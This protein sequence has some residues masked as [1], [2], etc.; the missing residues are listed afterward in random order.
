MWEK[1]GEKK[2]K[3]RNDLYRQKVLPDEKQKKERERTK[4]MRVF[5]E[6]ERE[7]D[8]RKRPKGERLIYNGS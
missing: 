7:N 1:V 4:S 8:D 2:K 6:R 3:K 5:L